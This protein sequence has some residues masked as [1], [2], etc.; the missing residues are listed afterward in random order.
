LGLTVDR[1]CDQRGPDRDAADVVLR[2]VDGVDDPRP[3]SAH[4]AAVLFADEGVVGSVG[5]QVFPQRTLDGL[6]GIGDG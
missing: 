4:R 2:T 5:L 3:T 1:Q 6:V